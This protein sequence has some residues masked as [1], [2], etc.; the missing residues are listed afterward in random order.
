MRANGYRRRAIWK[1]CECGREFLGEKKE[2]C[3]WCSAKKVYEKAKQ[4]NT[5]S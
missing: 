1:K 2:L 4:K 5:Q 3:E